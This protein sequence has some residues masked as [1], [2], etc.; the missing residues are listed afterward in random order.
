MN[1]V[2]PQF[3]RPNRGQIGHACNAA[4]VWFDRLYYMHGQ[5]SEPHVCRA[6][7][8]SGWKRILVAQGSRHHFDLRISL[9]GWSG[10]FGLTNQLVML[11]PSTTVHFLIMSASIYCTLNI[12]SHIHSAYVHRHTPRY[13]FKTCV[14]FLGSFHG[15]FFHYTRIT[16]LKNLQT[17]IFIQNFHKH[18]S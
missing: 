2:H 5:K 4:S 18:S 17:S 3:R 16:T 15:I 10:G 9:D 14:P 8:P 6:W 7:R 1:V 11:C 13:T 12:Y